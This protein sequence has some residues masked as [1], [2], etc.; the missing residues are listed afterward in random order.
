MNKTI[1]NFLLTGHK[2]MPEPHFKKSGF[3]NSARELFTKYQETGNLKLIYKN[4]FI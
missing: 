2:F 3:T 1:E 4:W